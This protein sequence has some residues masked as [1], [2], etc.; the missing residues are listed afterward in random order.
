M[1]AH[2][3]RP[4]KRPVRAT[5]TADGAFLSVTGHRPRRQFSSDPVTLRTPRSLP[6]GPLCRTRSCR[7]CIGS[8]RRAADCRICHTG[9]G[10]LAVGTVY[11]ADPA[12]SWPRS[13]FLSCWY[14]LSRKS[15]FEG[16]RRLVRTSLG[17]CS[18]ALIPIAVAVVITTAATIA[19]PTKCLKAGMIHLRPPDDSPSPRTTNG[20]H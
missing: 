10:A 2:R 11:L 6:A 13:I 20:D 18:L 17:R 14:S 1:S 9:E 8:G 12:S 16:V 5:E 7:E 4:P 19:I 15:V 3:G